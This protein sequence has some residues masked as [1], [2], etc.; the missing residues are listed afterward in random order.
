MVAIA[1]VIPILLPLNLPVQITDEARGVYSEIEKLPPGSHILVSFDYEPSS[2]PEM[3]PMAIA[4]LRHC[5]RKKLK[6]VGISYLI[7]GSGNAER[8]FSKMQ[9]EFH[10]TYG[11]DYAYMGYKPGYSAMV[12]KLGK[13]FKGTCREDY[14]G[15]NVYTMPL[16]E[17]IEGLGDFPYMVDLHDDSMINAWIIY[18]YEMTG[19]KIGSCCTA[20]MAP[21]IYANLNAGQI[22]GIVGGLKGAS[23][24]EKLLRYRGDATSGMDSQAVIH[25]LI[26]I[27]ILIGNTAFII[28]ERQKRRERLR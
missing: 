10:L 8:I 27:F 19:I 23:E 18:G 2:T 13:D 1:I 12:I 15:N 4:V 9:D 14:F 5:F 28:K 17:D 21:G 3:D 20:V 24:Y 22:T 25:I 16:L 7:L 11:K 6:V 26:V